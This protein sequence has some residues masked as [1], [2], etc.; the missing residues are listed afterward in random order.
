[1]DEVHVISYLKISRGASK[2][3][4]TSLRIRYWILTIFQTPGN[5]AITLS[6]TIMV[7]IITNIKL[8]DIELL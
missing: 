5:F 3:I 1:M 7:A 6:V 2:F 4:L 8:I